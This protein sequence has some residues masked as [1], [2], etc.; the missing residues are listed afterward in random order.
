M[1][2]I[3]RSTL[4]LRGLAVAAAALAVPS[5]AHAHVGF[6]PTNGFLNGLLHPF[7]GPD[8]VA[9][10]LAVG[11]WAAQR[12]G[13][14]VWMIPL[15]FVATMAFASALGA[16]G[17]SLPF[18]EPGIIASVLVLGLLVAA[19][20]RLPMVV[21]AL[22][23]GAFAMFHGYAHGAEMPATVAGIEYG[24]GFVVATC[25]LHAAGIGAG[26]MAQR[27]ANPRLVRVAGAAI[28]A[29]GLYLCVV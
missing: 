22:L 28:V 10:M 9:A 6:L 25:A 2:R 20:V 4:S 24:A 14:A 16:A 18:V 26:V 3:V 13:R 29:F 19:A 27:L 21:S 7:T 17:V 11:L 1:I 15:S 23:V 12:G 5:L 8:H